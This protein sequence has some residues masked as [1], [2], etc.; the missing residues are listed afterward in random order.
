MEKGSFTVITGRI[1]AGKTTLLKLILGL[2]PLQAGQLR[3]NGA[4]IEAPDRFMTPPRVSYTPQTPKLF[5]DTLANNISLGAPL[6]GEALANAVHD[7][8]LEGDLATMPARLETRIGPRGLRL[9]GGQVQRVAT[10]RMLAPGA[11]LLVIDD[12]SS[13]L[14]LKTEQLLWDRLLGRVRASRPTCLVVS[15]RRRVLRHADQV[16]VLRNGRL[17]GVGSLD[18]LLAESPEMRHIWDAG[19][20]P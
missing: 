5:S 4:L 12:L 8:V 10:A 1:G 15:H 18:T 2:L 9:S 16:V 13:A 6:A 14:D 11:Q 17:D 7:A 20:L 3:W 19:P